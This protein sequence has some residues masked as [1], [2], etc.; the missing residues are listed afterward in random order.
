MVRAIR[1]AVASLAGL[2]SERRNYAQSVKPTSGRQRRQLMHGDSTGQGSNA[3][4][5]KRTK[6]GSLG[7]LIL[8]EHW[9]TR[10]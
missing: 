1:L 8:T 5:H 7:D 3:C 2:L 10:A 4:G 9:W 6:R